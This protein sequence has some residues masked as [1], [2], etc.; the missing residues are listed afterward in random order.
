V[1]H[2]RWTPGPVVRGTTLPVSAQSGLIS[3]AGRVLL[4]RC[5]PDMPD[6]GPRWD[7]PG[8]L[9]LS[10][11]TP[12]DSLRRGVWERTSLLVDPGEVLHSQH[13]IWKVNGHQLPGWLRIR[14][15]ALQQD[16]RPT[17]VHPSQPLAGQPAG[18]F[19]LTDALQLPLEVAVA[20]ALGVALDR[21]PQPRRGPRS[22]RLL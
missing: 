5:E 3:Q 10:G 19:S 21:L 14:A 12:D 4:I 20:E 2:H 22:C 9:Q 1:N 6:Q 18:W 16:G 15:C 13:F 7:L 17:A 8:A 11:E